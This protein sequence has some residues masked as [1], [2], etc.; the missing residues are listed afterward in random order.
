MSLTDYIPLGIECEKHGFQQGRTICKWCDFD[1]LLPRAAMPVLPRTG[2]NAGDG[3][4][5]FADR[6]LEVFINLCLIGLI[7]VPFVIPL[8]YWLG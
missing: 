2:P 7:S 5:S 8:L 4:F 3:A 1:P 6:V